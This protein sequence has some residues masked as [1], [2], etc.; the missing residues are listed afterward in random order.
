MVEQI[1]VIQP[2]HLPALKVTD[3][4]LCQTLRGGRRHVGGAFI[5]PKE[6]AG[7]KAHH[8]GIPRSW[9]LFR[10]GAPLEFTPRALLLSRN[11]LQK[12]RTI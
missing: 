3:H 6:Y 12:R 8:Q 4:L 5:D 7:P 9:V 1:D 10:Q 11:N 2:S